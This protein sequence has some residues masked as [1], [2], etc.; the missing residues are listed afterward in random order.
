MKWKVLKQILFMAPPKL[1]QNQ[2][3]AGG[4][5]LAIFT[6]IALLLVASLSVV[7][8]IF[9]KTA[10]EI[11]MTDLM[12]L[13]ASLLAPFLLLLWG[14]GKGALYHLF[15]TFVLFGGVVLFLF[16]GLSIVPFATYVGL[17]AF[18][19]WLLDSV[20]SFLSLMRALVEEVEAADEES[21]PEYYPM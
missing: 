7:F 5:L 3:A 10:D 6:A 14:F 19:L 2:Q 17:A 12:R 16:L 15:R 11:A 20:R 9:T 18:A 4:R 1:S 13:G 8:L 21:G